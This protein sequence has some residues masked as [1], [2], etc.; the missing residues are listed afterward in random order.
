MDSI[1][2]FRE[3]TRQLECHL[4]NMNQA[5]CCCCGVSQTQ[6]FLIVE[7]V[8]LRFRPLTIL[9][10]VD[11][12]TPLILLS[13]LTVKSC[14]RQSSSIRCRTASPM[15]IGITSL[16]YEKDTRCP[17]KRLTLLSYN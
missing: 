3:Y 8:A 16:S 4:G 9:L 14:C 12:V 11:C 6:C 5:D 7:I 10:T 15:R 13:L 17:L 2:R 1:Q